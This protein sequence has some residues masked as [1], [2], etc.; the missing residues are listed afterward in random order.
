MGGGL[1]W[2]LR[3][4]GG[5]PLDA[6]GEWGALHW[7]LREDGGAPLDVEGEWGGRSTGR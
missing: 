1:H 4:N 3:E 5:T 2:T 7:T 6:E